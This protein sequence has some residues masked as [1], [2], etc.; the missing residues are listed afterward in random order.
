MTR[1]ILFRGL[2]TNGKGWAY[3]DLYKGRE[4]MYILLKKA[5]CESEKHGLPFSPVEVHPHTVGQFTG[6]L[7]KNG[8]KVFEG[9]IIHVDCSGVGGAFHDGIYIVKY[10]LPNACF[11]VAQLDE[12]HAIPFDECYYYEIIGNIHEEVLK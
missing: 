7:D 8:V 4:A 3:G 1:E 5:P 11:L 6:L 10:T 12:A 2:R 9:D